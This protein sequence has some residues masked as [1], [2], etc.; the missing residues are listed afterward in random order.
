MSLRTPSRPVITL[1]LGMVLLVATTIFAQQLGTPSKEDQ[2][3]A[4]LVARLVAKYHISQSKIDDQISERLLKRYVELLDPQKLYF[5][6]TDI[7][8]LQKYRHQLDDLVKAGNVD[9]AY[10]VF[11]LYLQRFEERVAHAHKM[12]DAEHDFSLDEVLVTD[13]DTLGWA[14][15]PADLDDR[16]R[17]R[18]KYETL[19][20]K[21]E[22]VVGD[23]AKE[24]LHKRYRTLVKA[25]KDTE[26]SEK[27]ETYLSAFTH[28]FDPHSSYM[29]PE[30]REEFKIAMRLSLDGI[31]AALRSEDGF[32][33]VAD[34]V[35]GGAA[36][37]D[38]RL[39][40]GDKI[41]GVGQAEGDIVDIV[42]MKLSKVVRQIRGKRGTVV[43]LRVKKGE[44]G[45]VVVYELTRKKID[46]SK[47]SAVR[48]EVIDVS[49]RI[50]SSSAKIGVINIPSFYR[51]FQG[52][53]LN[54][55]DFKSTARDVKKQLA[56]F[57]QRGDVDAVMIDLR[58]NGGGALTEAIEV[59]GLF[60]NEGPVV[61]VKDP[62]GRVR[63][64]EDEDAGEAYRGPLV[65]VCNRLSASASEIF[66]GAIKDYGRGL[67]VGDTT[68]H[69]KGTVQNVMDVNTRAFQLP[70]NNEKEVGALKLTIQQFYRV[71][72]DSTQNRG[73]RSHVVL[74]SMLDNM[75]LGEQ[76]LDNALEFDQI[77]VA[78]SPSYGMINDKIAKKLAAASQKR[79]QND[80]EF[81]KL[82][83]DIDHYLS[84]KNRKSVTLNESKLREERDKDKK[85]EDEK[86]EKKEGTGINEEEPIFPENY[87][88][89]ELISIAVDYL[90][91]LK[92]TETAGR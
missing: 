74:P 3:T 67:I 18:V 13:A 66:A 33:I 92:G 24:R 50:G 75:E 69:G 16:W 25:I 85:E 5:L 38:G 35:E 70:F 56:K 21:L 83:T 28:C 19:N 48:G 9:F 82:Q 54:L 60:I 47:T 40:V 81:N 8:D 64:H 79:I 77:D 4:R 15:T 53:Q 43:R 65:V 55:P 7:A 34:I 11:S 17:K 68:T 10:T 27:L 57:A 59:S 6:E 2:K 46:L 51:D 91:E 14:K 32:T 89:K 30:S 88:N 22:D 37:D 41:V 76:Y 49:D 52:A 44:S 61:Q 36:F 84:R 31:G 1:S 80:D 71:N 12:I 86:E 87:Y 63:T 23:E 39:K 62:T 26:D 29:S 45:E 90:A 42:E 20:L 73:V 58:S 72:G 78:P